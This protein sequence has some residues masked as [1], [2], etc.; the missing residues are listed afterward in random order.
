M[1]RSDWEQEARRAQ[2]QREEWAAD[3]AS[4]MRRA[5]QHTPSRRDLLK[6]MSAGAGALAAAPLLAACGKDDDT[7]SSPTSGSAGPT[8][9]GAATTSTAPSVVSIPDG[10]GQTLV[11]S[12]WGGETE[13]AFK[14]TVAPVF[15]ELTGADVQF[16]TGSGGERFNKLLAQAASP[17]VDVFINSGE[18]VFQANSQGLLID[19]DPAK[20]PNL[21]K[22]PDWAQLFPFGTSYGLLAYGIARNE[23]LGALSSWTDLWRDDLQGKIGVPSIQGTQMPA[24][25]IT[26]ADLYGGSQDDIEPALRELAKLDPAVLVTFWGEYADRANSGELQALTDFNYQIVGA[27]DAGI[28]FVFD[29]PEEKA[30]AADNTVSIVKDRPNTDLAHAFLDVTLDAEVQT[31]FC[32]EWFGS[33][34][35]VDATIAPKIDGRVPLAADI[36]DKVRFFDLEFIASHRAEWTERLNAEVLP[37]WE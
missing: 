22:I 30:I 24:F 12:V 11:V 21:S 37:N 31:N 18:N 33:P 27:Q 29:F 2:H 15:K 35:N 36:I 16:D 32:G 10:S 28:P 4:R 1:S 20:V 23:D 26:I 8:S 25:L 17:S 14:E 6:W 5:S 9:T 7:S 19:I 13:R 34:A 3:V